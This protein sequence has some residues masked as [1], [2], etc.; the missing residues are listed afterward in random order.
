MTLDPQRLQGALGDLMLR[1]LL[2]EQTVE[3][4][5]KENAALKEPKP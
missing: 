4:L 1:I 5:R 2:L 3:D